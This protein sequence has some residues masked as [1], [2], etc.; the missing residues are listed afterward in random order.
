MP[1]NFFLLEPLYAKYGKTTFQDLAWE[2]G[3]RAEQRQ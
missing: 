1:V 2:A 3:K